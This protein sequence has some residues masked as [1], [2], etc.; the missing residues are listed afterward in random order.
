MRKVAVV[1]GGKSCENEISVLT[2]VF[3]L[4]LIDRTKFS[5]IPLYVHTDGG[6]YTSPKMTEV[7]VFREKKYACFQ[8]VFLEG[9]VLYALQSAKRIKRIGKIDVA[10]NCCHGG[11]GEGGGVSALMEWN[12]IPLA[13]PDLTSSG[14]FM[15]KCM[16]KVIMR[17]LNIPTLDY[18]R[19][20]ET[21]YK[22]RGAFLL[23][24]IASRL[25]Y[26]VVIKPAHLGSSI[27]IAVA[28][29]EAEA[30]TAIESAFL[31]DTRVLIE[32]YLENKTDVNCAAYALNGEIF[33]SEPER[34]FGEGLYS[35]E[36]KYIKRKADN[37]PQIKGVKGDA[38]SGELR[39][40]IRSYTK[41]VYK[42]MNM[43]GVVR[44]DFLINEEKAY[45]CEVNT[46]P[47]SLAYYLFCER[48]FEARAFF[49][50][51]LEEALKEFALRDKK[52]LSTGILRET[53]GFGR[54]K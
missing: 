3:V 42:R 13:S 6:M 5:P 19:V 54:M 2:G 41:T 37:A 47:G 21:D 27:G 8:R 22:K 49:S 9:G 31:I 53:Q 20:N 43:Q 52:I 18:I 33:V 51:L 17:A 11:L 46:V 45:L 28:K 32:K 16:T 1:F 25:K 35:F 30:K 7:E 44:M 38:L 34:A 29:N 14:V 4:N 10:I 24:S 36:E 40:K 48:I 23:K 26:P 50:D 15:D 12:G 39:D